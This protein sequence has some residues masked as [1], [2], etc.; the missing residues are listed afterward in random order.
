MVIESVGRA[1]KILSDAGLRSYACT[2][3]A[4]QSLGDIHGRLQM[5]AAELNAAPALDSLYLL[6]CLACA[7]TEGEV[8][9]R[10]IQ[11]LLGEGRGLNGAPPTLL[12]CIDAAASEVF[13]C[14]EPYN[15]VAMSPVRMGRHCGPSYFELVGNI[16]ADF[17]RIEVSEH[18]LNYAEWLMGVD[19]AELMAGLQHEIARTAP[20]LN[21]KPPARKKATRDRSEAVEQRKE[22]RRAWV[23]RVLRS[24]RH[25]P[26]NIAQLLGW[27]A[28][29]GEFATSHKTLTTDLR[30]ILKGGEVRREELPPI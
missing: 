8:T 10:T 4:G 6:T 12:D 16:L 3:P 17:V 29:D 15:R 30:H 22:E 2:R 26:S 20:A 5:T 18:D 27:L 19:L 7:F 11:R 25:R 1:L 21:D 13:T 14:G 24:H 28:E 9:R 23:L